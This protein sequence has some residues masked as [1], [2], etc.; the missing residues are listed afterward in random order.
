MELGNSYSTYTVSLVAV[1]PFFSCHRVP[2]TKSWLTSSTFYFDVASC[3]QVLQVAMFSVFDYIGVYH[4]YRVAFIAEWIA[5]AI[6]R[7]LGASH[8]HVALITLVLLVLGTELPSGGFL[9]AMSNMHQE[10]TR[11]RRLSSDRTVAVTS[12][13]A[14]FMGLNAVA[15][16]GLTTSDDCSELARR[17]RFSN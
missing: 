11:Y 7:A 15:C 9:L 14:M 17:C 6:A 2:A 4:V 1:F 5:A 3:E 16:N 8:P 12:S 10:L 13:S